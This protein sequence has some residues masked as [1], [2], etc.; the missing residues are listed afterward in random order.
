M[1]TYRHEDGTIYQLGCEKPKYPY[2]F[3]YTSAAQVY[4]LPTILKAIA[5]GRGSLVRWCY[6]ILNQGS[7]PWCWAYSG[8]QT[9]MVLLNQL[10]GDKTILDPSMG[11]AIT[12]VHGGNAIDA[13]L[14]EV[15]SKYGQFP[16]ALTGSDPINAKTNIN[17]RSWPSAWKAEAAKRTAV[18]DS[19]LRC[20]SALA[21][22]SALIDMGPTDPNRPCDVGVS[23][24][25]G[26]HALTCLE[27]GSHDGASLFF[28]GPNSWSTSFNSGWGSYPGRPGW[29]MLTDNQMAATFSSNGFG[30]YCLVAAKDAVAPTPIVIPDV[31]APPPLA[32][33]GMD[34]GR[35]ISDAAAEFQGLVQDFR[36]IIR[37]FVPLT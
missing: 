10:F 26:G 25:G 37:P 4:D 15:Q 24:Q 7:K 14:E 30:A 35:A 18:V 33:P 12:G 16:A 36:K 29:W 34:A 11:P 8:T 13:M 31:P 9:L 23:W 22:A 3:A 20:H 27:V 21:L 5:D 1:Q 32:G 17:Q 19:V 6:Q 2:V 28:A